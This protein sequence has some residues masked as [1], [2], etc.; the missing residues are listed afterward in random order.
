[1]RRRKNRLALYTRKDDA[2]D[3]FLI[4]ISQSYFNFAVPPDWRVT[5]KLSRI[6]GRNEM[7]RSVEFE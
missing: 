4:V 1:M 7:L 6:K 3:G 5:I 2:F